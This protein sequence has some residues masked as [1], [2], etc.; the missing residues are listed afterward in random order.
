[1]QRATRY[2]VEPMFRRLR[3]DPRYEIL[4]RKMSLAK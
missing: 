3:A 2:D 1:M 4:L